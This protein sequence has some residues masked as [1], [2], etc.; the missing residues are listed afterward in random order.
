MLKYTNSHFCKQKVMAFGTIFLMD[1]DQVEN[2]QC[3]KSTKPEYANLKKPPPLQEGPNYLVICMEMQSIEITCFENP[4]FT[5]F[6][7]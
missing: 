7:A 4:A 2:S 6:H 3:I 5:K 1:N